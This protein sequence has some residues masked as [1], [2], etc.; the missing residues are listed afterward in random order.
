MTM[1]TNS[2]RPE[3]LAI[4]PARGGSKGLPRKNVLPLARKP[5]IVHSIEQALAARCVTRVVVSTDDP[6]IASV[7]TGAKAEVVPRPAELAGDTAS[8]ESALLHALEYLRAQEGYQPELLVFLQCT[9]PVRR[10]NDIDDAVAKLVA[11]GADSLLSVSPFH[12]FLW[13]EEG[14]AAHAT[15]YD[16]R[17]RPRRQDRPPEFVETGSIY[18]TKVAGLLESGNRLSGR[19]QLYPMPSWTAFDIDDLDDFR[20][21]EALLASKTP[22]G[23]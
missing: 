8:S 13:S 12:G 20:M 1:T 9:S 22:N 21:C 17:R 5:L 19:I 23:E 6:E 16:H 14:G 2:Q 11:T 15:N 10:P 7:A 4:I 3:I 18:V